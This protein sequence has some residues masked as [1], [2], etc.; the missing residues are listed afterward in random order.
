[1]VRREKGWYE[2]EYGE[3]DFEWMW[4][5]D[6]KGVRVNENSKENE[7][8]DVIE[9]MSRPEETVIISDMNRR[10]YFG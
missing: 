10:Y 1:L 6:Q 7:I 4:V 9:D 5:L 8:Q 2:E 3:R